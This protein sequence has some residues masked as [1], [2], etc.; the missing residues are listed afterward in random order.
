M[1]DGTICDKTG[2]PREIEVQVRVQPSLLPSRASHSYSPLKCAIDLLAIRLFSH[3]IIYIYIILVPLL[4]DND[5]L[6]TVRKRDVNVPLHNG[7]T[8]A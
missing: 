1:G 2:K 4:A 5:G 3:V 8:Y 6:D 7:H